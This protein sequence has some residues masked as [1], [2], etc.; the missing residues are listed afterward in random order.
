MEA[1]LRSR[2]AAEDASRD[3]GYRHVADQT[4]VASSWSAGAGPRHQK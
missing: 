2:F 3:T 1:K 4:K